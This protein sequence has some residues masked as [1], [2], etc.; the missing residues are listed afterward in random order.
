M[1]EGFSLIQAGVHKTNPAMV[2]KLLSCAV[3]PGT[4]AIITDGG[5]ATHTILVTS[6]E[7][8]GCRG[9]VVAEDVSSR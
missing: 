8:S 2:I 3:D 4:K 6:G 1:S 7:N 5:F 9:D